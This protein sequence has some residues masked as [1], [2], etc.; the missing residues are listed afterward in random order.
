[1]NFAVCK[2]K[3]SSIFIYFL[4]RRHN[5]DDGDISMC[6]VVFCDKKKKIGKL[7]FV[8]SLYL[9]MCTCEYIRI[10]FPFQQA[11]TKSANKTTIHTQGHDSYSHLPQQYKSVLKAKR[12]FMRVN[13][14][15]HA[16]CCYDVLVFFFSLYYFLV[17][18]HNLTITTIQIRPFIHNAL[19]LNIFI[20]I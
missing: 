10:P 3:S 18:L 7:F 1:M 17:L 16:C 5:D 9:L 20:F 19:A 12:L 15:F 13:R 2:C 8:F 6:F 4:L 14:S 11:S